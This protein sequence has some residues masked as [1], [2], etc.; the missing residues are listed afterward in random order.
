MARYF[1]YSGLLLLSAALACG[2]DAK[3]PGADQ[4]RT[5]NLDRLFEQNDKNKDGFLDKSEC[6]EQ[7]KRRF[8][9]LDANKD[10]KLSKEEIIKGMP[11]RFGKPSAA[12]DTP[13]TPGA[14]APGSPGS[15]AADS[16][17]DLL[18]TNKDGKL[19][20]DELENA[21]KLLEKFDKNKDGF[22]D[23]NELAAALGRKPGEYIAPAAKGERKQDTLKVGD[24]APDFTLPTLDGKK[25]V[26]LSSFRGQQPVV[27]VFA[28]YT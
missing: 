11:E 21:S 16:L 22:I 13:K 23:R 15:T 4:R 12:G 19:S 1:L 14:N 8:E 3:K 24:L 7:L 17:F 6:P 18:D 28:S 25:Y 20:K 5:P 2:D 27:L 9:Q 26:E 10:G